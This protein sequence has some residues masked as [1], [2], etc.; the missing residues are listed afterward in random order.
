MEETMSK[1][2]F[3]AGLLVAILAGFVFCPEYGFGAALFA[4]FMKEWRDW[5]CYQGF[6]W[7]D[8]VATWSGGLI[9]YLLLGVV[10]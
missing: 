10:K 2:H 6:D 5:G 7:R 3:A 1:M 8:M 4:G 9:G